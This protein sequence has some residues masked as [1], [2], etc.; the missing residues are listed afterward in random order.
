M[1]SDRA[2]SSHDRIS[3]L[4]RLRYGRRNDSGAWAVTPSEAS[5]SSAS[6]KPIS[7]HGRHATTMTRVGHDGMA[8]V[9]SVIA[10]VAYST[11]RIG[12]VA[13]DDISD[14]L[15]RADT[16]VW[17]GLYEPNEPL[18]RKFRKSS[19]ST[20]SRLKTRCPPTSGQKWSATTT[21]CSSSAHRADR[22]T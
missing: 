20:I 3:V 4:R 22:K 15:E 17:I 2:D 19:A 7:P 16:F 21:R 14:V 11:A 8:A 1:P 5:L 12:E 18:L 9:G 6:A 10:S 13:L